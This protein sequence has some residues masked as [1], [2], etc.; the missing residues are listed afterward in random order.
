MLCNLQSGSDNAGPLLQNTDG[1]SESSAEGV[2][3][4]LPCL[5]GSMQSPPSERQ[6]GNYCMLVLACCFFRGL[7]KMLLFHI[8][9]F[10]L[11][12]T[13]E[14]YR[15]PKKQPFIRL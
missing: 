10:S 4:W 1:F 6:G 12:S 2:G 8:C 15:Q 3:G 9:P 7:V 13:S 5:P 11:F 14:N